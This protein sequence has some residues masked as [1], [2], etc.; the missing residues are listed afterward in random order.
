[1]GAGKSTMGKYAARQNDLEFVD[2]DA[3][4]EMANHLSVQDI[5]EKLGEEAFRRFERRALHQ[6]LKEPGDQ[7][8]S[9]GGGTP[10]FFDNM[11]RMNAEGV[12]VYIDLSSGRLT[13]RLRNAKTPRPLLKDVEGD[14][15]T[16]I[17]L[18]LIERAEYYGRA[19]FILP[20]KEA[21]KKDLSELIGNILT[22]K[23]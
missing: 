12:T 8:I 1:M 6:V 18:K 22:N 16:F 7:L 13:D 21:T 23:D 9:T 20:E 19:H 4:I 10:C 14:L 3:R 15:Q 11:D 17:H 2:L 5:F